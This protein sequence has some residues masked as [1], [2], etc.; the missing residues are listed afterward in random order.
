MTKIYSDE[1][2]AVVYKKK[3]MIEGVKCDV[4]DRII[5]PY[6]NW[7]LNEASR[8][9]VVM[10][11]HNDWGNDSCDSIECQDICPGCIDKFVS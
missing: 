4:C 11:G 10:T 9:F 2:K 7:I 6:K 5:P 8:Y 1:V 3:R